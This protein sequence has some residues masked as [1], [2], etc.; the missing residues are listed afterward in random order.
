M[1]VR[2]QEERDRLFSFEQKAKETQELLQQTEVEVE[3]TADNNDGVRARADDLEARARADDISDD[4]GQE[5][6]AKQAADLPTSGFGV[7]FG[8]LDSEKL[9]GG[10]VKEVVSDAESSGGMSSDVD[11]KRQPLSAKKKQKRGRPK[12]K[13]KNLEVVYARMDATQEKDL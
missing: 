11:E 8:L 1:E 4:V 10:G 13:K 9:V 3:M 5:Y 12:N 6:H 7:D 2:I